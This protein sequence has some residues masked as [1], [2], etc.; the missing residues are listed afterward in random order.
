MPDVTD[1]M[2]AARRQ[3]LVDALLPTA[4]P[5]ARL[6][7]LQEE[8]PL[9]CAVPPKYGWF[10]HTEKLTGTYAESTGGGR[11]P[12]A[13][14]TD[15]VPDRPVPAERSALP[16]A[17][18]IV[19]DSYWDYKCSADHTDCTSTE[20]CAN[21][22]FGCYKGSGRMFAMCRPKV[23]NCVDYDW[24]CPGWEICAGSHGDC[25][26]SLCCRAQHETCHRRPLFY[27]AQ[28]RTESLPCTPW[29]ERKSITSSDAW[30]CPGWE[31]LR[32]SRR[33][34]AEPLLQGPG[35]QLLSQQDDRHVTE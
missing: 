3:L 7:L 33:V 6:R 21:P 34:H 25:T 1:G 20:C 29:R 23:D 15:A 9:V 31:V 14:L 32:Q 35:L 5:R 16:S 18:V 26:S 8:W 22:S 17:N 24:L 11:A 27:Y 30:L 4:C 13:W 2:H 19:Q 10:N 28:C 12:E